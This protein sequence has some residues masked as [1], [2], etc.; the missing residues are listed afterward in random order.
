MTSL[1]SAVTSIVTGSASWLGSWAQVIVGYVPADGSI[2]ASW[3]P[4][5]ITLFVLIPLV[6]LGIGLLKRLKKC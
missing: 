3:S 5:I 4:N 2:A 6:G 1:I